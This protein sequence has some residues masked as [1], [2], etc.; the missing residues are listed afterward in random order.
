MQ[1]LYKIGVKLSEYN[2]KTKSGQW[3]YPKPEEGYVSNGYY[4]RPA[5]DENGN[6]IED[7]KIKREK[8]ISGGKPTKSLLPDVLIPYQ[9][10]PVTIMSQILYIWRIKKLSISKALDKICDR[11]GKK[12]SDTE[13]TIL[14][15][16]SGA[17]LYNFKKT[18]TD[19]LTK[20]IVWQ[21]MARTYRLEEFIAECSSD[22]YEYARVLS[23]N[24]YLSCDGRF[25]FGIP[26]QLRGKPH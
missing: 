5:I 12:I 21:K 24:Y 16:L 3:K 18:F 11:L 2:R 10:Y 13:S 22:D 17:Q 15:N 26:S 6:R 4:Y 9:R 25:L 1:L 14:D 19:A 7:L 8:S 23:D 20:Y